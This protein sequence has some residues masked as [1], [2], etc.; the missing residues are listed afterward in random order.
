M[1]V[2][3][4]AWKNKNKKLEKKKDDKNSKHNY[5]DILE[6]VPISER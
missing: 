3:D 6:K 5:N 4:R 2:K 1:L